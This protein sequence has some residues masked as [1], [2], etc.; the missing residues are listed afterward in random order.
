MRNTR[1][2]QPEVHCQVGGTLDGRTG[3]VEVHQ[4]TGTLERLDWRS[5]G[6]GYAQ[7]VV[8]PPR[9]FPRKLAAQGTVP[10]VSRLQLDAR[11]VDRI[12]LRPSKENDAPEF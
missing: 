4:G 8:A 9:Y 12:P 1:P 3:Q 6:A 5:A 11:L 2:A 10:G 7:S